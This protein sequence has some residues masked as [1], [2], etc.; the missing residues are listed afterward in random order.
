MAESATTTGVEL[1]PVLLLVLLL[2]LL[3]PPAPVLLEVG[4]VRQ[5]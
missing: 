5:A 1:G 3:L 4:A 2:P